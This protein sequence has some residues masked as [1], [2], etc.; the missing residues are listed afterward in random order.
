M[1]GSSCQRVTGHSQ[2]SYTVCIR[3]L[4]TAVVS[5]HE[6]IGRSSAVDAETL[7]CSKT[8]T[9]ALAK[10]PKNCKQGG[11][12]CVWLG[13][14]STVVLVLVPLNLSVLFS[15]SRIFSIHFLTLLL[16][17]VICHPI[18]SYSIQYIPFPEPFPWCCDK[19]D[20]L[21]LTHTHPSLLILFFSSPSDVL[22]EFCVT[23]LSLTL[24][25]PSCSS[26]SSLT[27]LHFCL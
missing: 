20:C 10:L 12:R 23:T 4:V 19:T 17:V 7:Y 13:L 16:A 25:P 1:G 21:T 18:F 11:G 15:L 9:W 22:A 3:S 2:G 5:Q 27:V 14:Y 24:L 8:C 26:N 6:S